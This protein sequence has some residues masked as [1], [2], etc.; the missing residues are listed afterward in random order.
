MKLHIEIA[1]GLEEDEVIIRCSALTAEIQELQQLLSSQIVHTKQLLLHKQD[2][3]YYLSMEDILFFETEGSNVCAHTCNDVYQTD[4]RLY[5]LEEMLPGHFMRVAKSTILNTRKVF[6]ITKNFPSVSLVEFSNSHKQ[7]QVSR[8][9]YK[10]L[11]YKLDEM[12]LKR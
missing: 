7:V 9:Y 10:A 3:E 5:E 6:S 12:R 11:R 1:D 8:N 2:T 4:Y